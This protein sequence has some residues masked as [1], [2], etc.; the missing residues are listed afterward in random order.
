MMSELQKVKNKQLTM[1][2][3]ANVCSLVKTIP[4]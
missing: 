2:G 4:N 1:H 3:L